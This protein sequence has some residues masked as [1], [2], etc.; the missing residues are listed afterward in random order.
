MSPQYAQI[1]KDFSALAGD[2]RGETFAAELLQTGLSYDKIYFKTLSVFKRPTSKDIEAIKLDV[3]DNGEDHI[4]LELNREGLYDMLPEGIFHFKDIKGKRKDKDAILK[5]IERER[6]EERHARKFFGP[7]ENEFFQLRLQLEL[8]KRSL[9]KPGCAESN[10]EFFETVFGD[11]SMLTEHQ[12]LV[13]LY[14]LPIAHKIRGDIEKITYCIYLLIRYNTNIKRTKSYSVVEFNES[15]PGM[16][17]AKLGINMVAGKSFRSLELCYDININEIEKENLVSFFPKGSNYSVVQF[18][19]IFLFPGNSNYK[20][21]LHLRNEDRS[22]FLSSDK[23]DSYL[24]FNSY[25]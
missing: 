1:L 22:V 2:Y 14:I 21:K 7:F 17:S 25:L 13:L 12:V 4:L 5:N 10:R 11:A 3:K 6:E 16:G 8:K 18:V 24:G 19:F 23:N 20:I 9:L 15:M